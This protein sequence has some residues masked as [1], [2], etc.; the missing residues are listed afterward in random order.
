MSADRELLELTAKAAAIDPRRLPD[1]WPDRLEDD[2][3]SPLAD[4]GDALRLAVQLDLDISFD[5]SSV[6]VTDSKWNGSSESALKWAWEER[7]A[8]PYAQPAAQSSA[9]L[10]R[11]AGG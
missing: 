5:I 7:A 1:A 8:D 11:L 9:L 10:P 3:W 4:D 2:Q 6:E